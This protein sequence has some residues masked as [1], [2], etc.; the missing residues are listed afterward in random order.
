MID[1]LLIAIG[2]GIAA[3][4]LTESQ[5]SAIAAPVL[6]VIGEWQPD[7]LNNFSGDTWQSWTPPDSAE[8]YLYLLNRAERK[9]GIPHNLLTRVAYQESRFRD[10]IISGE[11]TSSAG[12]V[13]IMQIVPR[14]H[15][16]VNPLDVSAAIDYAGGY[17]A[18]LKK[19]VGSW[20]MALAAYNWGIG[21]LQ[22]QGWQNA[23]AETR[24]YVQQIAGDVLGSYWA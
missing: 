21:N 7:I 14:W 10:D 5:Q 8:P 11:T 22:R 2:A 4:K 24:Q 6:D 1:K 16:D 9:H 18:S 19:Q 13:G 17:L 23:P 3:A 12:A 20:E 15:P